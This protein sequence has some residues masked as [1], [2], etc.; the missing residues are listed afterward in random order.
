M[1]LK[2]AA[3]ARLLPSDLLF[4]F[5]RLCLNGTQRDTFDNMF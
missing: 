1:G 4:V 3:S 5:S 2:R